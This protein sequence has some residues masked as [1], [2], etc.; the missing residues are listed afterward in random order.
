MHRIRDV[1]LPHIQ[2][3][4]GLDDAQL[5]VTLYK[6]LLYHEGGHFQRHRD[7]DEKNEEAVP[8]K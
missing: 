1:L 3:A 4:L 7:T 6:L 2:H 8:L 5:N